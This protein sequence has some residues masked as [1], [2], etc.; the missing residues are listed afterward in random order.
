MDSTT[1]GDTTSLGGAAFAAMRVLILS[2]V[3]SSCIPPAMSCSRYLPWL[4]SF[5]TLARWLSVRPPSPCSLRFH[6]L[7]LC[8]CCD[9]KANPTF[10]RDRIASR[11]TF[12][13]LNLTF[14][15]FMACF[16]SC[17]REQRNRGRSSK[18]NQGWGSMGGTCCSGTVTARP[19]VGRDE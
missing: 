3:S 2:G 18:V 13:L 11:G 8:C 5:A 12:N 4:V 15:C 10:Q 7:R 19:L 14:C 16:C 6:P 9:A 1:R 17:A